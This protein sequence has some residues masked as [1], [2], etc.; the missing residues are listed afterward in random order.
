M[1]VAGKTIVGSLATAMEATPM[2]PPVKERSAGKNDGSKFKV[3][4]NLSDAPKTTS[5]R[6]VTVFVGA[7]LDTFKIAWNLLEHHSEFF[8]TALGAHSKVTKAVSVTLKD[9]DAD[10]FLLFN[11]F[12][13]TGHIFSGKDEDDGKPKQEEGV[14]EDDCE[15]NLL[16]KLWMKLSKSGLRSSDWSYQP[17]PAAGRSEV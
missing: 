13:Q 1:S 9:V 7:D 2:R 16:S 14:A 11:Y 3:R 4:K 17:T 5:S 15:W 12:L 10:H 8:Q 6:I